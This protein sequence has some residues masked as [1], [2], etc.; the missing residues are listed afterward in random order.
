MLQCEARF[1][2]VNTVVELMV[3]FYYCVL[4]SRI[5]HGKYVYDYLIIL[6]FIFHEYS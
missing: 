5:S 3:F 1:Y 4:F 2:A 6:R